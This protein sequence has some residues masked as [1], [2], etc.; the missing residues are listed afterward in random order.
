[1]KEPVEILEIIRILRQGR[2]DALH[3]KDFR[4]AA[5]CLKMLKKKTQELL[6][7]LAN[8][9]PM[10]KEVLLDEDAYAHGS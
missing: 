10:K 4:L 3:D 8:S 6:F 1:M 7:S 2:K 9:Q 5:K